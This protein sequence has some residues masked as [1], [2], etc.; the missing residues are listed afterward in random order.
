M[1]LYIHMMYI[2]QSECIGGNDCLIISL[3][4][5]FDIVTLLL[6][7]RLGSIGAGSWGSTL[8]ACK[9][10]LLVKQPVCFLLDDLLPVRLDHDT[11]GTLVLL[12]DLD[13]LFFVGVYPSFLLLHWR[14]SR[15]LVVREARVARLET[16]LFYFYLL[17]VV[18]EHLLSL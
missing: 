11:P 5:I 1:F 16:G 17:Q 18:K 7:L 4:L 14:V 10:F 6:P 2:I 8:E 3:L 9:P 12:S 13:L 15:L